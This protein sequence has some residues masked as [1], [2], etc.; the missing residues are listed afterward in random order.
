MVRMTQLFDLG[1]Q[2]TSKEY[3]NESVRPRVSKLPNLVRHEAALVQGKPLS[4]AETTLIVDLYFEDE[5][6]MDEAFASE[7]GKTYSNELTARNTKYIH[8][9]ESIVLS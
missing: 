1:D 3:Y 5:H 8:A 6:K 7:A 2:E 4:G 9:L